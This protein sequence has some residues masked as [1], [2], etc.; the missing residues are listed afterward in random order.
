M[1]IRIA[2]LALALVTA[3]AA[4]PQS[5]ATSRIDD[6]V[7]AEMTRQNIPGVAIAV[8]NN[9]AVVKIARCTTPWRW[10]RTTECRSFSFGRRNN[11]GR[12]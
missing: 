12:F 4:S 10:R 1:R 3:R 9:G 2:L 8:V 6:F 11:A 7:R 5:A